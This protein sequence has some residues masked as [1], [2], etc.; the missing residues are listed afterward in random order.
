MREGGREGVRE[1]Y[2]SVEIY[3]VD[4]V[5]HKQGFLFIPFLSLFY[6]LLTT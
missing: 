3:T 2:W 5:L 1:G 6:I 4:E